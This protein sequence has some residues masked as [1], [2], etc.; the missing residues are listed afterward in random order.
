[1]TRHGRT[2]EW[3]AE[4]LGASQEAVSTWLGSRIPSSR[5]LFLIADLT[6][7]DVRR[8]IEAP[9]SEPKRRARARTSRKAA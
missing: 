4:K 7:I 3:V 8:W 1:M 2:Q 6:D 5:M 9:G